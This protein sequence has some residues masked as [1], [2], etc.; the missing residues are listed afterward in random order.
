[1]ES[2]DLK[3][4]GMILTFSLNLAFVPRSMSALAKPSALPCCLFLFARFMAEKRAKV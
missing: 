4:R 1:M 2:K 3:Q